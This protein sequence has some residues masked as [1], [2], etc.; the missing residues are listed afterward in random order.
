VGPGRRGSP[1][2][3]RPRWITLHGRSLERR[4]HR[5]RSKSA[6]REQL[7]Y[8]A[9][10]LRDAP[11]TFF[12]Q[13]SPGRPFANRRLAW[14]LTLRLIEQDKGGSYRG[15]PARPAPNAWGQGSDYAYC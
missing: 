8:L 6:E 12:A 14:P 10:R 11:T 1:A 15:G 9:T 5:K 4:G 3:D 2:S 13:T 7:R